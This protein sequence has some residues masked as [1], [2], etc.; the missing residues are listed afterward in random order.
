MPTNFDPLLAAVEFS[1][2][3]D[4]D[5]DFDCRAR[6]VCPPEP[7]RRAGDRLS[8][9]G[10]RELSPADAG[11]HLSAGTCAGMSATRLISAWRSSRCSRYVGDSLSYRQDAVATEAYL[12]TARHR[13]SA[14][15]HAR[16]VDYRMHDGC[17]ARV[18]MHVRVNAESLTLGE[19]TQFLTG[20]PSGAARLAPNSPELREALAAD[21]EVF[22]P[23][24]SP[25]VVCRAQRAAL[26]HIWRCRVLPAK[27]RDARRIA[28]RTD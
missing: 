8:G 27:R 1:F 16:L 5:S 21:P 18:W 13:I 23:I 19:H 24:E 26:L 7:T 9:E 17:N 4:V 3:V 11:P 20:A 15:R 14:R 28:R 2:N 6:R 22:E 12:G 10:L 25:T